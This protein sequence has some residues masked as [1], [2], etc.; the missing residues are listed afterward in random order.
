MLSDE[1]RFLFDTLGYIIVH[2]LL[3]AKQ[4][5]ALQSTLHIPDENSTTV[6][7]D[8]GPLHWGKIWRDILDLPNLSPILEDLIGNP[9]LR[10][11]RRVREMKDLPTYRL[12]HINVHTH[13]KN[14]YEGRPLHGGLPVAGS[15]KYHDGIFYNGLTV[16][17]FE[18]FDTGSN[19]GGFACIPGTHKANVAL[20]EGWADMSQSVH[21]CIARIAAKPGDAIIFTEALIHGSLPWNV[22]A[23]RR[24]VFYKFSPITVSWAADFFNP[25][26]F[27]QYDDMDDRKLAVLEPPN[28]RYPDRSTEPEL[29]S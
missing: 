28:A 14:G 22:D 25:I 9:M 27:L 11:A 4:V 12:D 15:F 5:E 2:D 17:S 8:E 19:H 1:Q 24:T 21:D 3:S 13:V 7:Q 6:V 23:P 26:D 20:P 16:V 10:E 29:R 18:L